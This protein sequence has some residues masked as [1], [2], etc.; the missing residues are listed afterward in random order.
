MAPPH[1]IP[2]TDEPAPHQRTP[3]QSHKHVI[4]S[5]AKDTDAPHY[6]LR[7]RTN[8][9]KPNSIIDTETGQALEYH[10]PRRVPNKSIWIRAYSNDLGRIAQG[11]GTR[12]PTGTNTIY[13]V[14]LLAVP[15]GCKVIYGCLVATL[16]PH[17]EEV[18]NVRVTVGGDKLDYPGIT[19]THCASLTTTKCLL[20]S[21][22]ST[23]CSK[24]LVIDFEIF[25][26]NMPMDRYEY[27][28]LPLHSIH[29]K[30]IAQYNLSAL[31][32]DGWVYLEIRK[33]IPGLK[34]SGIIANERL[35]LH[36]ANHVYAPVPCTLSLWSHTHFLIMFPLIVNNF[37]IKYTGDAAAHH[38]IAALRSLYTISL[39]WS[40]SLFCGLNLAWDYAKWTVNVSMPGY[41]YEA[42]QKFQHPYP[43]HRQYDPHAWAQPVYGAKVQ[44]ADN[45]DDSPVLPPKTGRL[46]HQIDGNLLYYTIAVDV[47]MLVDLSSIALTQYKGTNKTYDETLW[48]LNYV[49]THL[50]ATI[51]YSTS[52]IIL[53]V[54]SD[55][56][57][58]SKPKSGSRTGSHYFLSSRSTDSSKPLTSPPH[59]NGLLYTVSKIMR[60][61]MGSA[62]E[63]EIGAT[64][65][66]GQESVPIRTTLAKMSYPQPP[67]PMQ[68]QNSTAEGFANR[69]IKQK[70]S[71]AI[72]VRFYWVQ[73]HVRQGQFLIYW[74]PGSTNL[75]NYH[76]KHH[77]P[78]LHR[79]ICT[80]YLHPT[81]QLANHDISILL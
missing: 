51:S 54:H 68:V 14:A 5:N 48:F 70:R 78:A 6:P 57:Y 18:H 81:N 15:C 2:T 76:T 27:M 20:N 61:V 8:C 53:H 1:L 79:L 29:D 40:G 28:R 37:G 34:Q 21:K 73:D 33:G 45:I 56:S 58:L 63:A 19:A 30:I 32:L 49:A 75:V 72:D 42:L 17:K 22:L 77:S 80:T 13:F 31:V 24:F 59:P 74:Q 39:N 4:P 25:H 23:P 67:T 55:A 12:M 69:T 3:L 52:Y 7:Y 26:Y 47:T 41:I 60:N 11:V 64:Y 38:L 62:A 65:L 10:Y 43:K 44:H 9:T 46:V 36:L 50:D 71:K 66:N 35:T 16:C